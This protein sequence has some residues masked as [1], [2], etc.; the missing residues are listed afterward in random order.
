M[1]RIEKLYIIVPW[2]D[3]VRFPGKNDML[4]RYTEEYIRSEIP[5]MASELGFK[6]SD[7]HVHILTRGS[8]RVPVFDCKVPFSVIEAPD[9]GKCLYD[10][11]SHWRTVTSDAVNPDCAYAMLQ[12]TQP[13]RRKG[14]LVDAVNMLSSTDIELVRSYCKC[15]DDRWRVIMS[16]GKPFDF[17]WAYTHHTHGKGPVEMYDGALYAAAGG[18]IKWLTNEYVRDGWV[19]NYTGPVLD[20]DYPHEYNDMYIRGIQALANQNTK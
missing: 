12:V 5:L 13:V 7:I 17:G 9:T 6:K 2:K 14:M 1:A 11:M 16:D 19:Y 18:C 10:D 8:C 4:W 15:E 20:I 3:S